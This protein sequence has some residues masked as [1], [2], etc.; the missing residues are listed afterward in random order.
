MEVGLAYE[1]AYSVIAYLVNRYGFWRIR[2]ILKA[3]AEHKPWDEV[4]AQESHLKLSRLEAAWRE[5]LPELLEQDP[6]KPR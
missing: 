4:L 3:I 5:W 2:R 1:Q 6:E